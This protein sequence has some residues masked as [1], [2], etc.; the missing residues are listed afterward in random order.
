M[1]LL[2]KPV[3]TK[4]L[5]LVSCLLAT[6]VLAAPAKASANTVSAPTRDS[7]VLIDNDYDIDD[8]KAIPLVIGNTYVAAL[9]QSEGYTLPEHSAPA[10]NELINNLADQP[11]NRQIPIIVGASQSPTRDISAWGWLPF[12]RN[13]MNQSNA[14]LATAPDPWPSDPNYVQKVVD[15]VADCKNV[16]V[17]IIGTYTSFINYSPLIRDKIDKVVVMGQPIGDLSRTPERDSFNCGYDLPACQAAMTQL[18]GLNTFFVDI[19]R[20]NGEDPKLPKNSCMGM[21]RSPDCYQPSF[22]MV[23]GGNGSPGLVDAGLPGRLKQAL[24]N[25]IDCSDKFTEGMPAVPSAPQ[26]QCSGLSTWVPANVA[27]GPGGEMLFWDET[28]ALFL[29]KPEAFSLYETPNNPATGGKHWEPKLVNNS[30]AETAAYLRELWTE[31]TN[32]A[33]EPRND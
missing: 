18:Q 31:L 11:N 32:K 23:V 30:Y 4:T 13:M 29:V 10:V 9:I 22:E 6:L 8:M 25:P 27:A 12:F 33:A 26:S 20:D 1:S 28:A 17:L 19:P 24:T 5:G 14:L 21:T 2:Q 7:C 16:S 15:A 3:N